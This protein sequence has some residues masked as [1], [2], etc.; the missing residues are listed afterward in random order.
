MK[1]QN[2]SFVT[3]AGYLPVTDEAFSKLFSDI[4]IVGNSKY[5]SMYQAVD[6]M[7]QNYT[8]YKQPLYKNASNI[9]LGFETNVKELLKAAHNQYVKR[10]GVGEDSEAVLE[11][12]AHSTLVQL[13]LLSSQ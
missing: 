6:T 11:E 4:S 3:Q 2:L 8:F 12:L 5:H 10:I 13:K 1:Q 9:Q 7:M